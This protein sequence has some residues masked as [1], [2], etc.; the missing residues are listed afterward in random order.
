MDRRLIRIKSFAL[1]YHLFLLFL[2]FLLIGLYNLDDYGISWDEEAQ[3]EIGLHNYNYIFN[4][5]ESLKTF[6]AKDYGPSF[7]LPLFIIEKLFHVEEPRTMY[8]LRHFLSHLFFL[9]GAFFCS[10]LVNQLY[11]NKFL[12]TIS[13]L[14]VVMCP[15]LYE[16]SFVNT[17][18]IPFMSMF[19]VC[20]YL[21]YSAFTK[22]KPLNF[23]YLG[24]SIGLLI[25]LRIMGVLLFSSVL[26]FL[27]I[28]LLLLNNYKKNSI[29]LATFFVT[30]LL[31]AYFSWPYLWENPFKNFISTFNNMSKFNWH[32]T[33]LFMGNFIMATELKWYYIP[34][35]FCITI[36]LFFLIPGILGIP[37]LGYS[38]FT[39]FKLYVNNT[40]ERNNVYYVICFITPVIAV[41][42]FKSVLYDAWRHLYFIYAPFVLLIIYCLHAL[43]LTKFKKVLILFSIS[44]LVFVGYTSIKI[45]PFQ[46]VYFNELMDKNTPEYL[47][48]NW[49]QDYWGVSY[50]QT[51]EYILEHDTS[52]KINILPEN[53]PGI[54]NSYI[55]QSD[56]RKRLH[57][58]NIDSA[59]YFITN[60]R[61]HPSDYAGAGKYLFSSVRVYN[62]SINASYKIR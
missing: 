26:V 22:M 62:N 4:G 5:S 15:R 16:D 46:N 32:Q 39:K 1:T 34:V 27:L 33:N 30:T 20:F 19:F 53:D 2:A 56:K 50:R 23:F 42:L 3:R 31:A 9:I 45:H 54:Y 38:L 49:E 61:W 36:P 43:Y 40:P 59:N 58:T 48:M 10:K 28:D 24:V 12:S 25:S 35:W 13:F 11:K 7:E 41:I 18:D 6:Y 29:L 44:Y 17:K 8:L 60:F 14:L 47:K 51:L 21:I 57:F 55:L 37:L 52:S